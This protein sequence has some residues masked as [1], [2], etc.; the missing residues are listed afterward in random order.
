[1]LNSKGLPFTCYM[2][3][4]LAILK[5]TSFL[6]IRWSFWH[7][8]KKRQS[9]VIRCDFSSAMRFETSGPLDDHMPVK[10]AGSTRHLHTQGMCQL[11]AG[12]GKSWPQT[13]YYT[14]DGMEEIQRENLR[15]VVC[16]SHYLQ[17]FL[18]PSQT[19]VG[20]WDF[21]TINSSTRVWSHPKIR[22][23]AFR[24][25]TCWERYSY[26]LHGSEAN[27]QCL[28]NAGR[29]SGEV[30]LLNQGNDAEYYIYIYILYIKSVIIIL[31]N[32]LL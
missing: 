15:L 11:Q 26:P 1:M 30:E 16:S 20:E 7:F 9:W 3:A 23:D 6:H 19:V 8:L 18:S 21:W 32:I 4:A 5:I 29:W 10:G 31:Y 24:R 14:V 28:Q 2:L 27:S 17:S 12:W 13:S 22:F 25:A